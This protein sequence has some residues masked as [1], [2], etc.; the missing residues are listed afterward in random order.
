MRCVLILGAGEIQVPV[1]QK[2]KDLG[3]YTIVADFDPNAPGF[4]FADEKAVVS[5]ID[6][7]KVNDL[8]KEKNISG[9]LTTSD[10]P[11]N[12]VAKVAENLGLKAMSPSVA[13]LCTNKYLQRAFFA[14]NGIKTPKFRLLKSEEDI[15]DFSYF[16]SIVKPVDSSASRGVKK[17]VNSKDLAIQFDIAISQS[18]QGQVI[19]EDYIEGR[20]FSVECFV[21]NSVTHII[22]ITEKKTIGEENGFFVEDM[23]LIPARIS[24]KEAE[25]IKSEVHLAIETMRMDNCPAHV[26]IKLNDTGA[27]I[28]EIACRLGGDYITSD[29]VPLSTGVDMLENLIKVSLGEKIDVVQKF[30]RYSAIQ[31]LNS[32]NY[33]KCISFIETNPKRIHKQAV[34]PFH[35]RPISSSGDRLGHVIVHSG[36]K[37]ELDEL[38]LL[39]Q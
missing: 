16:P 24:S 1:I 29:L 6:L 32:K 27:Y 34:K 15:Q 12:I 38:I 21:Q 2:A 33:E 37:N 18:K 31:F 28:I 35:D 5:T 23:H 3:L 14:E 11:V 13:E 20:E 25:L 17:V 8:A 26:E 30:A 10:Y 9:I 22:A 4:D 39:M 7:E 36:S 19:V